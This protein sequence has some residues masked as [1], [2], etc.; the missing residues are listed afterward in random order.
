[1]FYTNKNYNATYAWI[2]QLLLLIA[3]KSIKPLKWT[4][5][6]KSVYIGNRVFVDV[7]N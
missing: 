2:D 1:M 4:V 6:T 5:M 7:I 3:S